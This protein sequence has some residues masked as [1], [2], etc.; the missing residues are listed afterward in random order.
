[1]RALKCI[2]LSRICVYARQYIELQWLYGPYLQIPASV[3]VVLLQVMQK[4]ICK[5]TWWLISEH[6]MPPPSSLPHLQ[7]VLSIEVYQV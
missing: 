6:M 4:L 3:P 1:M 2:Q 5:Y 7:V